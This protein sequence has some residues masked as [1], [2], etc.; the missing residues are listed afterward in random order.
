M[1]LTTM[2]TFAIFIFLSLI[3]ISCGTKEKPPI[4]TIDKT[5][6]WLG[7]WAWANDL[8]LQEGILE[9]KPI[10]ND[11]IEFDLS[12]LWGE[13]MNVRSLF[14][15]I[16]AEGDTLFFNQGGCNL[17]MIKKEKTIIVKHHNSEDCEES[18]GVDFSR[19]YFKNRYPITLVEYPEG[20]YASCFVFK[21]EN[22]K[23]QFLKMRKEVEEG[24]D[25][26]SLI[27]NSP[28]RH[29][30][31]YV[32]N[33]RVKMLDF[34][35]DK[36]QVVTSFEHA[37]DGASDIIWQADGRLFAFVTIN[38]DD[39]PHRTRLHV[40]EIED[41]KI[42]QKKHYDIPINYMCGSSCFST[43]GE[44]F[45]WEDEQTIG[46]YSEREEVEGRVAKMLRLNS[47]LEN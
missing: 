26:P 47:N 36:S 37:T 22:E 11:S 25:C 34:S 29:F 4:R 31:I 8:A 3:I 23:G 40:L 46:Y 35:S 5:T 27:D 41:R 28:N 33:N 39:V 10:E 19:V 43:G 45:W 13:D 24:L 44:D 1:K 42:A 30:L 2:K 6:E 20:G 16:K 14:G 9:I 32:H 21:I 38:Q 7:T 12:L 18:M 17:E 15:K